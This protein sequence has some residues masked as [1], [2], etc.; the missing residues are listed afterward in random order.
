MIATNLD[1]M[2]SQKEREENSQKE[3]EKKGVEGETE[4]ARH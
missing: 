4:R 2:G 1:E 3:V